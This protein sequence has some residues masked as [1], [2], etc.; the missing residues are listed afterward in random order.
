[1]HIVGEFGHE[2]PPWHSPG[3]RLHRLERSRFLEV[4]CE[5]TLVSWIF[6]EESLAFLGGLRKGANSKRVLKL[7]VAS[8]LTTY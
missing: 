6:A 5:F 7:F 3:W 8:P 1:M 2:T 4:H